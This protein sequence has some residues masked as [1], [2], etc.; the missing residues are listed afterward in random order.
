MSR[1]TRTLAGLLLAGSLGVFASA[2]PP[3]QEKKKGDDKAPESA[4]ARA[5]I[6]GG[7]KATVW[8]AEPQF[9]NPVA[10]SFDEQGKCYVVEGNRYKDGVPDTRGHMYWLDED[11]NSKSVA[12]RVAM[13]QKHKY[14]QFEKFEDKVRVLWDSTGSGHADKAETFSGGYNRFEDGIAAGVL[15]R[16][17]SVYFACIPDLYLL[18]DTTGDHKADVKQ[19]LATGF[20]VR[21]QFQGHD[22][23]G[24]R[25]GPDG[26]LY[27]SIGDR[28]FNVTTKDGKHLYNPDS[29]AVLRCGPDGANMEI[30]HTGL[31][32]PQE[33][34]FDDF[35]NL[36]TYDNNCD[37]GDSA[38][39]VYI[40]EGGD[41]GCR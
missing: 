36:F 11:I 2:V 5:Q 9:Q 22:L 34:A 20:G 39:W 3:D 27:F 40:V 10:F 6:E 16:K 30:V 8:A 32:N 17:G 7:L 37:S 38:R 21:A 35:G 1:T 29:G 12:D 18:K 14:P 33:L 31:R 24:L 41:S 25:M 28:G 19:S 26:K 4:A 23:H 15:A 13:Y